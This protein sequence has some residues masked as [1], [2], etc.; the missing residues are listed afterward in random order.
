MF[1]KQVVMKH[2]VV[3]CG[4]P[5]EKVLINITDKTYVKPLSKN[6]NDSINIPV[7]K[8]ITRKY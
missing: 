2:C 5:M 4:V 3:L 1:W 6:L 7:G 8:H